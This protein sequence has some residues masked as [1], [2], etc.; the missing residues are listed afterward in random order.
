MSAGTLAALLQ[1][2]RRFAPLSARFYVA[3]AA[4]ALEHLQQRKVVHRAVCPAAFRLTERGTPKLCCFGAGP[5]RELPAGPHGRAYSLA[6]PIVYRAPEMIAPGG[7][8]YD[9]SI[10]RWA[11][12]CFLYELVAGCAPFA[13]ANVE[14]LRKAHALAHAAGGPGDSG[15]AAAAR[16]TPPQCDDGV[17]CDFVAELLRPRVAERLGGEVGMR[18]VREHLFLANFPFAALLAGALPAPHVPPPRL[19]IERQL[20]GKGAPSPEAAR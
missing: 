3:S 5:A 9:C 15:D 18:P 2:T 19:A 6:G 20:L 8:G 10:D 7:G 17:L 1:Q 14:Q 12:G 4:A 11:L 13:A 16:T